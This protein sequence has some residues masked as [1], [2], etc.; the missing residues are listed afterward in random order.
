MPAIGVGYPFLPVKPRPAVKT[1]VVFGRSCPLLLADGVDQRLV[2]SER[3]HGGDAVPGVQREIGSAPFGGEV[4]LGVLLQS[5]GQAE[6][7]VK[8]D[9][10]GDDVLSRQILP[11]CARLFLQLR[12]WA[13]PGNPPV[14]T[15]MAAL[16]RGSPLPVSVNPRNT[17]SSADA[18][19]LSRNSSSRAFIE[20]RF[21]QAPTPSAAIL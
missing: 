3:H 9:Q 11:R 1:L 7:A 6:M 14:V 8:V 12:R 16:R 2:G 21:Y 18:R 15:V 19:E 10:S 5:R 17:W 13:H 4:S 20:G